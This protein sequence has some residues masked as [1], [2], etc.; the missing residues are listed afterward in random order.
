[1]QKHL[2][3]PTKWLLDQGVG[4]QRTPVMASDPAYPPNFAELE[5]EHHDPIERIPRQVTGE[6][7]TVLP[8]MLAKFRH[9]ADFEEV[10]FQRISPAEYV[11]PRVQAW[12]RWCGPQAVP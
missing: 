2:A 1:M 4:G 12:W 8:A 11:S 10:T 6:N 3:T 7:H 9:G 5:R